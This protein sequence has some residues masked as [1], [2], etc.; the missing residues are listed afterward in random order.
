MEIRLPQT[1]F[2]SVPSRAWVYISLG[3][4]ILLILVGAAF[5][6]HGGIYIKTEKESLKE[7]KNKIEQINKGIN[8]NIK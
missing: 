2:K 4:M 6:K 7:S 3:I 8:E 5:Y 1:T